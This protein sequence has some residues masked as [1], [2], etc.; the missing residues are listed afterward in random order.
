MKIEFARD[1]SAPNRSSAARLGWK[2][3]KI[4]NEKWKMGVHIIL[5][6]LE[7][8]PISQCANEPIIDL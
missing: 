7:N 2:K 1:H 6:E 5:K 8:V 4:Q 3:R